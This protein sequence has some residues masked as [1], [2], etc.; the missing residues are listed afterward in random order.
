M[1][2]SFAEKNTVHKF[3]FI[4]TKINTTTNY[5]MKA[6][7]LHPHWFATCI[8]QKQLKGKQV[9][10]LYSPAA[11]NSTSSLSLLRWRNRKRIEQ[12]FCHCQVKTGRRSIRE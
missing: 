6:V 10:I 3:V 12:Y 1:S 5:E 11:V 4:C 8:S 9:K 7:S 2:L